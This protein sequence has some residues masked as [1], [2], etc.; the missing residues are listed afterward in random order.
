MIML[1][2]SVASCSNNSVGDYYIYTIFLTL[3]KR[4]GPRLRQAHSSKFSWQYEFTMYVRVC[5]CREQIC[6]CCELG[7][8]A[9]NRFA[10][11]GSLCVLLSRAETP[12]C[13]QYIGYS[14]YDL[15]M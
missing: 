13:T 9:V 1:A 10:L 3:R 2:S 14:F 8:C 6:I 15:L 4:I 7:V 5:E 12:Q 11:L